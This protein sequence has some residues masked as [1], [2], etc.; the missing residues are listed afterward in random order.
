MPSQ[1]G[2]GQFIPSQGGGGGGQFMPSHGGGPPWPFPPQIFFATWPSGHTRS[3]PS[4]EPPAPPVPADPPALA[5][6]SLGLA[7][8]GSLAPMSRKTAEIAMRP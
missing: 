3:D 1:G 7:Q 5:V 2:G 4:P 8:P 6:V